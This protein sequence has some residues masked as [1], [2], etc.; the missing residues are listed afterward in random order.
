MIADQKLSDI[1]ILPPRQGDQA[2]TVPL[3][4]CPL[5]TRATA[6]LAL[7]VGARQEPAQIAVPGEVL[8]QQCGT[9]GPLRVI[10]AHEDIGPDDGLDPGRDRL[11][12]KFHHP[13]EIGEIGHGDRRH[14][15]VMAGRHQL[16]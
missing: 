14:A 11:V 6:P 15:L 8:A 16:V 4:P 13:K 7:A 9:I 2:V 10:A 3:E 1:T 12:V 5:E